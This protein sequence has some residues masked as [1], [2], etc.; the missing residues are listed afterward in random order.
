[1]AVVIKGSGSIE[2]T[3]GLE[4]GAN[5]ITEI[6]GRVNVALGSSIAGDSNVS[7]VTTSGN[8]NISGGK[9]L[10]IDNGN[11]GLKI[12]GNVNSS[13]RTNDTYKL[14]RMV[15]PHYHNA[16]EPMA[17]MQVASDGTDNIVSHG[18][19]WNGANAATRHVFY[20]AANDATHTG[21]ERLRIDKNG[22]VTQL[23]SRGA[24]FCAR[25]NTGNSS[26]S[27]GDIVVLNG[28]SDN[29][30]SFDPLNNY[31][32][33]T[34]KYTAPVAGVYYF[35]AQAMTTGWSNGNTT[36]DLL[37]LVSNNGTISYPRDRRSTFDS[38]IDANGYF[39]NSVSGM[40][41][42]SAGDTVWFTVSQSCGVSNTQYSY[43]QGFL[44]G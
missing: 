33:S 29:W 43:F 40:T 13:G 24:A 38:G 44:I 36:Q 32:T 17:I 7:G 14:A 21:T 2:G 28:M 12:G 34:G 4:M 3:S 30:H 27:G 16:E 19:S 15:I 37:A 22:Y 11:I 5:G 39:T 25:Q 1:M 8:I 9:T 10:D 26:L 23:T 42:L 35:E 20:T 18:G 6:R 31:D 41:L